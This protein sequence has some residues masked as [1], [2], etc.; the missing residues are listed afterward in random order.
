MSA[1]VTAYLYYLSFPTL[2]Q[3]IVRNPIAH[4]WAR[5]VAAGGAT[6]VY[7]CLYSKSISP[8]KL[9]ILTVA[10]LCCC[11]KVQEALRTAAIDIDVIL[12]RIAVRSAG[13]KDWQKI[14]TV[15]M[16]ART[17]RTACYPYAAALQVFRRISK[18]RTDDLAQLADQ[19]HTTC[20]CACARVCVCDCVRWHSTCVVV[21]LN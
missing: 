12:R 4:L 13:D 3:C 20:T 11:Q 5:T 15:C 14:Q 1:A 18:I 9:N 6:S 16:S 17:I 21:L 2:L 19:I 8:L 7:C 10:M